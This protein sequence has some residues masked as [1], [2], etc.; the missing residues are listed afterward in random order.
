MRPASPFPGRGLILPIGISFYSFQILSYLADRLAGNGSEYSFRRFCLFVVLFPQ[1]VAGPIVRHNE[2]ISQFD[3]DPWRSGLAER[4]GR[5]LALFI[6]ALICK[7]FIADHLALIV[8]PVFIE[9][10]TRVPE[11][12]PAWTAVTAFAFQIFFDFA[13]YSEM[14]IGVAL[15]LGLSLPMNFN[16]PYRATNLR[17]F[18]RRWHM[19]LSRFFRDYLYIPLGG[20]RQGQRRYIYATLATMTLCGLWHG[21]GWTFIIWGLAHGG[22]LIVHRFWQQFARPLPS[23]IDGL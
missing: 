19:T 18:W 3:L 9:S 20:S 10:G 22:G 17:D 8:D 6:L 15:M 4:L 12:L 23:L 21:A 16:Q 5:G 7:I 13:A 2:I 1:L 14:A 11:L